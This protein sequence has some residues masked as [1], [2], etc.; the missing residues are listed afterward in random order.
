MA[1]EA[2]RFY[3]KTGEEAYTQPKVTG[4]GFRATTIT[5][6]RK[7]GLLPS[8]TTILSILDSYG[9]NVWKIKQGIKTALNAPAM[10]Q[11][12]E[13]EV[14]DA[15]YRLSTEYASQKA[16]EG[17]DI[18]GV[19]ESYFE[20]GV[21]SE[22]KLIA[23]VE[24]ELAILGEQSWK[25]EKTCVGKGYAGKVDLHSEE[26]VVDF[27]TKD[28]DVSNARCWDNH[29]RQVAAYAK[30]LGCKKGAIMFISRDDFSCKLVPFT[31]KQFRKGW[32][33]FQ[34][35]LNLYNIIKDLPC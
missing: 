6:A 17:T 12:D 18:H 25:P 35:T 1:K 32:Q 34:A 23:S 29:F 31:D 20:K 19:I 27:K 13:S 28:G 16:Q 10:P 14:I 30:A 24:S 9:L 5:D 22:P 15:I 33:E 21:T 3:F 8:V 4:E 26:W 11:E 2:G 7:L